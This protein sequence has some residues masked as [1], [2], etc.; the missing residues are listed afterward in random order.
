MSVMPPIDVFFPARRPSSEESRQA[1]VEAVRLVD[2]INRRRAELR[3][4][5]SWLKANGSTDER[6]N[7]LVLGSS[8]PLEL[9]WLIDETLDRAPPA[10]TVLPLSAR[11]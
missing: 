2:E 5:V 11:A 3:R 8:L 1:F 6:D 7:A 9:Y 4:Q 10:E